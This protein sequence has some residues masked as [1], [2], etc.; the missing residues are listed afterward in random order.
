[1]LIMPTIQSGKMSVAYKHIH[2]FSLVQRN[3]NPKA[4]CVTEELDEYY[5]Y[6]SELTSEHGK[7]FW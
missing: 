5:E 7:I 1:M 3:N 6:K 4:T 2:L